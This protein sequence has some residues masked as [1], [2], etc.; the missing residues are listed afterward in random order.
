MGLWRWGLD[1]KKF[2]VLLFVL[3]YSSVNAGSLA[4]IGGQVVESGSSCSG[5]YGITAAADDTNND[6]GTGNI[7][8]FKVTIDCS[9]TAGDIYVYTK[10]GHDTDKEAILIIYDSNGDKVWSGTDQYAASSP[11]WTSEA[12][13]GVSLSSGDYWIGGQFEN[14]ATRYGKITAVG[15]DVIHY[16]ATYGT[17]PASVNLAAPDFTTSDID[18][19]AYLDF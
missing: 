8:L 9:A 3:F 6:T 4:V 12:F 18:L 13:S 7:F 14:E 17:I 11:G 1:M 15:N 16:T 2:L 10:Y 5:T 19:R